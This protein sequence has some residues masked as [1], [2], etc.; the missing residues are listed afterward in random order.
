MLVT[1]LSVFIPAH[2]SA[3]IHH[4]PFLAHKTDKVEWVQ[5]DYWNLHCDTSIMIIIISARFITGGKE[6]DKIIMIY[7]LRRN[8][9]V[10]TCLGLVANYEQ[11][12]FIFLPTI[13]NSRVKLLYLG[14]RKKEERMHFAVLINEAQSGYK[15]WFLGGKPIA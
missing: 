5:A 15:Y 4:E 10:N 1:K 13:R 2:P 8:G 12:H 6:T 11:Q 7:S 14:E 3:F 9:A